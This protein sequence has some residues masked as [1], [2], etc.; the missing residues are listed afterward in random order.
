MQLFSNFTY[1]LGDPG[2]LDA[3]PDDQFNQFDDRWVYGF[4]TKRAWRLP[5]AIPMEIETGLQGRYDDI[6]TVALRLTQNR[7]PLPG[8]A[9]GE[10]EGVVRS[11]AVREASL[12]AYLSASQ[13]WTPWFRSTLGARLDHYAFEVDSDLPANSGSEND[14]ILS[15]KLALVLGPFARTL[16]FANYGEGFHS[17]DARGV[18][19]AVDPL[20]PGT[21]L[22][23]VDPLVK[24]RGGELG[25][26][27]TP[28]PALKLTASLWA[29]NSDSELVYIGDAGS[30]EA[31]ASSQ[32]R[33]FELSAYYEPL[34]W[35]ALDAD[36]AYARGRLDADQG[37][38]IPNSVE[39]VA[40]LGL[41]LPE[42]RGWSAGLRLRYLGSGP[43]V[44]DNRAR[45]RPTTLVNSQL[46]YRW[47]SRYLTQL[48]VLNL[49]DSRDN[50]ITYFYASRLPGEPAEGVEDI[51]FHP[52]EPRQ[53]RLT[54][55]AEF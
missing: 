46:G 17:N 40:S 29:L 36:Y 15:P 8:S 23:R 33:G 51:H 53:I 49:F 24:S 45:S 22:D 54:L 14:Q 43:L 4:N 44:E 52:V 50:D 27:S 3:L 9:E 25:L 11:D 7:R 34:T 1:F 13:Q 6:D 16:L 39:N 35:L 31:S 32:R 28:F 19:I 12:G 48:Q 20:D 2:D 21:S 10:G 55:G 5:T 37:N 47:R 42:T 18:T 38:R 26:T 41:T 30:S